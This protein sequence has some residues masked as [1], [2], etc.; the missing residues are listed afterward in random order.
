VLVNGVPMCVCMHV[1]CL[2]FFLAVFLS[3]ILTSLSL[4][5]CMS[6][7]FSLSLLFL[8]PTDMILTLLNDQRLGASLQEAMTDEDCEEVSSPQ[9]TDTPTDIINY[10]SFICFL[11]IYI[12]IYTHT[13]PCFY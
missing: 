11:L 4:S 13:L 5:L 2:F 10:S 3:R 12:Y 1:M 8:S 7:F 9:H 6:L